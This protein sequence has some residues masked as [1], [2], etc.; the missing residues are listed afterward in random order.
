MKRATRFIVFIILRL[1]ISIHALVKRA[2]LAH[3]KNYSPERA[4]S[5]HALVKRATVHPVN[6]CCWKLISIHALVKRATNCP[7]DLTS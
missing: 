1:C 2:T 6:F 3:V 4:I 5:I 7:I